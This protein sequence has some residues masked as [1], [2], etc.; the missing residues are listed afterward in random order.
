MATFSGTSMATPHVA[1]A[2]AVLKGIT[3]SATVPTVL[4]ALQ[5]TGKPVTDTRNSVV[6]P[7]IRV[8]SAGTRLADT[9]LRVAALTTGTGVDA[10]SG[11][12]GT[13]LNGSG[14]L[15]LNGI[16][17]GSTLLFSRLI[18]TTIGGPDDSV[19][20]NGVARPG[21]LVG[22]GEDT[23]RNI[24]QFGPT[25]TYYANVTALGNGTY[26][27]SGAGGVNGARG[28][29]ATLLTV[30]RKASGGVGRVYERMGASAGDTV[31]EVIGGTFVDYGN[32]THVRRPAVLVAMG[33]GQAATDNPLRFNGAAVTPADFFYSSNG[34]LWDNDRVLLSPS[35]LPGGTVLRTVDTT[36]AGDCLVLSA[37]TLTTEKTA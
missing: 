16:P 17:A 19:V 8:L 37:A 21:A 33:D 20:L 35:Q 31:G 4:S 26:T 6:K 28:L 29:G 25:R 15:A 2:W 1:G 24:N 7:R 36:I 27:V 13:N 10:V 5:A 9:G 23:C 30:Y 22:A 32:A 34:D 12:V 11:G 3:P 18:W 14:T